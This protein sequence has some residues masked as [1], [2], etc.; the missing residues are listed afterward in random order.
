MCKV[1]S[2]LLAP[3]TA[4]ADTSIV[5]EMRYN[6]QVGAHIRDV[7]DEAETILAL[8]ALTLSAG[9]IVRVVLVADPDFVAR[10]SKAPVLWWQLRD[11]VVKVGQVL[12]E[13]AESGVDVVR[14]FLVTDTGRRKDTS[15]NLG[16]RDGALEVNSGKVAERTT[17][18]VAY[19]QNVL[20]TS[21]YLLLHGG[22]NPVRH[23]LKSRLETVVDL[24]GRRCVRKEVSVDLDFTEVN[25]V[26]D[27]AHA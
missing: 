26:G 2:L 4:E 7:A 10:V 22:V 8:V 25:V 11:N 19:N 9:N 5:P 24:H 16:V 15:N 21:R 17:L 20:G 6:L 12:S 13:H 18:R 27:G 23:A 1:C 14:P 3:L